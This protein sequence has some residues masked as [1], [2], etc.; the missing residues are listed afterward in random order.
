MDIENEIKKIQERNRC[1]EIDKE[2]ETSAIRRIMIA[3]IT[4]V[5]ALLFLS[6]IKVE[7]AF[8][9][10]FVPMGGFLIS[11]FSIKPARKVWEKMRRNG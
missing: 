3:I 1:V 4:F 2:W 6:I 9:A 10:A 7:N 8:L 11:T 5:V